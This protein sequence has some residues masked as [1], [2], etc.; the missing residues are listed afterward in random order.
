MWFIVK[1]SSW[2]FVAKSALPVLYNLT[3]FQIFSDTRIDDW[4]HYFADHWNQWYRPVVRVYGFGS[5]VPDRLHS[6]N[7][8]DIQKNKFVIRSL[9]KTNIPSTQKIL[10]DK[11]ST[12]FAN[13][14]TGT[15]G[16]EEIESNCL[17]ERFASNYTNNHWLFI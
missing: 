8:T 13:L 5:L 7:F 2:S 9:E 10:W 16:A 14:L 4:F 15:L 17:A 11:R 3:G 1:L 6:C 12:S